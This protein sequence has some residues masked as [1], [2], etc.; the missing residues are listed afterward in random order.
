M[1]RVEYDATP[2][3]AARVEAP[4]DYQRLQASPASFGSQLGEGLADVGQGAIKASEFYGQVAAD[5]GYNNLLQAGTSILYGKTGS[6]AAGPDGQQA[7]DTGFFGKR[8]ADAMSARSSTEQ[9]LDDAIRQ[10]GDSLKTPL[11]RHQYET[12]SRRLRAQWLGEIGRHADNEQKVWAK[13]TN[14][15]AATLAQNDLGRAPLDP[16]KVQDAT[17]RLTQARVRNAQLA[18]LDSHGAVLQAQQESAL[19]RVRSLVV[20]DPKNAQTVLDQNR[21]LLGSLPNYDQIARQVKEADINATMAPA[22]DN[23]VNDTVASA[24]GGA[25]HG[26]IPGHPAQAAGRLSEAQVSSVLPQLV[27]GARINSGQRTPEQNAAAGGVPTSMHLRGQAVDFT[28]PGAKW[29]QADLDNFKAS[30][31][32]KGLP[33][34]ELMVEEAGPHSTG[35]HVHWGW[36]AKGATSAQAASTAARYSSVADT[37]NAGMETN[38]Q[39]A[40]KKAEELFPN[41]PDAQDR[42]VEGARRRLDQVVGQQQRQ[43]EVD[44]HTVQQAM[45]KSHAISEDQLLATSPEVAKAWQSMQINNPMAAMSVERMF[46]ANAK[47]KAQV[48]GSEFKT[49]LDRVLAPST[50]PDRI[51]NPSQLYPFVGS[52]P[53]SPL[54]NTGVGQLGELQRLRGTPKGEADVTQIKTFVD[55]MHA[56]M[57]FSNAGTGVYDA[58]GEERFNKFMSA[59]LPVI[60]QAEKS[61]ALPELLNPQSK[62]FLG[63]AAAPFMRSGA[64]LQRDQLA[65]LGSTPQLPAYTP[66]TLSRTLNGLDND[67]QRKA[68]LKSAVQQHR[69]TLA[70]A[71]AI[72]IAR[73]YIRTPA[74]KTTPGGLPTVAPPPVMNEGQ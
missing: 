2:D 16:D 68:A 13:D 66:E 23:F 35:Y 29:T 63:H 20:S 65:S 59:N 73:G 47:G 71:T 51:S 10:N 61:G 57:T 19:T 6:S 4:D 5:N 17:D 56:Q 33:H 69:I 18:G 26:A 30:L 7:Q 36:G 44:T 42:F 24:H 34:T 41:Y 22:L 67:D 49:Y 12:D 48:Y 60:L 28:P 52:D 53:K 3:V 39:L 54:T 25:A 11:A 72:G 70:Q 15:T 46:D 1:A 62:D 55:A 8:G 21:G 50:D 58:K 27:P 43:Y 74:G 31:D 32:E 40:Q 38:L 45:E 37:L 9:A 64:E 14:D